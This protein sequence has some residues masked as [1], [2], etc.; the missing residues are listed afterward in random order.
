MLPHGLGISAFRQILLHIPGIVHPDIAY[1][2]RCS[3]SQSQVIC[4]LP[5]FHI[6]PGLFSRLCVI[7]DFILLQS[8][9]FQDPSGR[10]I[11]FPAFLLIRKQLWLICIFLIKP[12]ALFQDQLVDGNML[13]LLVRQCLKLFFPGLRSLSRYGGDQV[14]ADIIKVCLPCLGKPFQKLLPGMDPPQHL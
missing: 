4:P 10:K 5:V 8:V 6:M 11:D 12:G 3:Q 2:R 14:C 7:G 13:Q 9:F 1:H